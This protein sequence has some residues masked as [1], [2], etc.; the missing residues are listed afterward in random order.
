MNKVIHLK[1]RITAFIMALLLC[2]VGLPMPEAGITAYASTSSKWTDNAASAITGGTGTETDPYRITTAAELALLASNN[3]TY[4]TASFKLMND[5]DLSAHEW[6]PI[7]EFGGTF[8]GDGKSITGLK[9]GAA[10]AAAEDLVN[11]HVG[12]FGKVTGTVKDLTVNAAIYVS[13]ASS[14]ANYGAGIIAGGLSGTIDNC[15]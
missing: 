7:E 8:D 9:I 1:S 11:K 3:E 6:V 4:K 13:D 5:I 2:I 10:D 14:E 12:L 15:I